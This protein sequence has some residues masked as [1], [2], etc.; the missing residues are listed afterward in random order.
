[1]N[2]HH[3]WWDSSIQTP[4][5]ADAIIE[6]MENNDFELLNVPNQSTYNQ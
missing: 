5:R 6:L 1:M 4:I 2:A 3:E